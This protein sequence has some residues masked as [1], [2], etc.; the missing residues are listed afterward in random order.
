MTQVP[1]SDNKCS[2]ETSA[3]AGGPRGPWG[4]ED[5]MTEKSLSM[6][7]FLDTKCKLFGT[8]VEIFITY[9]FCFAN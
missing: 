2:W 7:G 6:S 1:G 5:S 9:L 4:A 8:F 3:N